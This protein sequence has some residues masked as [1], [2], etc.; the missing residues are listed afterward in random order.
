MAKTIL[1]MFSKSL[2]TA[3]DTGGTDSSI[4]VDSKEVA[5]SFLDFMSSFIS[6]EREKKD[7]NDK[8]L[9]TLFDFFDTAISLVSDRLSGNTRSN[10]EIIQ[11]ILNSFGTYLFTLFEDSKVHVQSHSYIEKAQKFFNLAGICDNDELT[12]TSFNAMK[13]LFPLFCKYFE[14]GGEIQS[15]DDQMKSIC[16]L[17]SERKERSERSES[18]EAQSLTELERTFLNI[19]VKSIIAASRRYI[20][21]DNQDAQ[22]FIDMAEEFLSSLGKKLANEHDM[23]LTD[24]IDKIFMKIYNTSLCVQKK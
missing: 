19:F 4:Q 8:T 10:D 5:L 1:N 13:T 11:T 16:S 15:S 2:T 24:K 21:L 3:G 22:T 12:N 17:L 20:H 14:E 23:K 6:A 9:Q 7:P 18:T